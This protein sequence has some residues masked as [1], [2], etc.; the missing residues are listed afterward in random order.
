MADDKLNGKVVVVTGASSGFG[1]GASVE[2]ARRGASLVLASR[3]AAELGK[4]AE[5][6]QGLGSRAITVPTDVSLSGEVDTL[7]ETAISEFGR[8]DVWVNNAGV[9]AIGRFEQIPLEDHLQ[10]IGTDLL[11]TLYG[12]YFA[13]RQFHSQGAG[14]LINIASVLG[15]VPA[16]YYSSYAAA[17]HG[18]VGLS[19]VLRQELEQ[20]KVE[21]IHVCTVLPTSFDTPFFEHAA[22]YSGH[23]VVPIPPVYDPEKVVEVIVRLASDP[24]NEVTVGTAAA[25][26]V[27]AH[28]VVPS[29]TEAVMGEQAHQAL[30]EEAPEAEDTPGNV[31]RP[32]MRR[33]LRRPA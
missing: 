15:K 12:S 6:C 32:S 30:I 20:L 26:S 1:R 11:G 2:F 33:R 19:A 31:H 5:E 7:A 29:L 4:L 13:M 3:N 10:V 25:I 14:I 23:K 18:V 16:P 24:E 21:T 27:F 8:I 22:N 17:K 9:G 28:Q